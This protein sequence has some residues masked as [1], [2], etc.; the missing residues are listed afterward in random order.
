MKKGVVGFLSVL[1][2]LSSSSANNLAITNV[3]LENVGA[4]SADI[5]FDLS[6]DNSWRTTWSD[7]G[8]TVTVTNWDAVWV[9]IK[10]RQSG[11]LWQHALLTA[12]GHTA[13]GGTLVQP[14]DDSGVRLGA[15]VY[16]AA[17]SAGSRTCTDM[18]LRWDFAASGLSGTNEVDLAVMGIEMVYIPEGPF[19]LGSGGTEMN[20]FYRYPD[21][22]QPFLVTN[23]AELAVGS[24]TGQLTYTGGG[25]FGGPVPEA[26]PKGYQ[27]FYCMKYEMTEGQYT[28]FLNLL[29]PGIAS[30]YYPNKYGD[31]R[32]AITWTNGAYATDA[33][34]RACNYL[35]GDWM[36]T[37]FDW[38]GL[39]PMTEFEF[40]KVCRGVKTPWINE[41][42]W[43]NTTYVQLTGE[44]GVAG[45]GA[46]TPSPTNANLHFSTAVAGPVRAGLFAGDSSNRVDA[47][48]G[49]YGN[50][51]MSGNLRELAVGI[52]RS[53][54][55][56]FT[57]VYGD[58]NEYT[59]QPWP[60]PNS[61]RA[62]L[63]RGGGVSDNG[64]YLGRSRTS[65][66]SYSDASSMYSGQ[67]YDRGARGVRT[68]P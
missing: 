58:G 51:E 50:M 10:F 35:R 68:T 29:D 60:S 19:S 63:G 11:G 17:D 53:E 49:Y 65:D 64:T 32:H 6:W 14:A 4:T 57:D 43:G 46:E 55:R 20:R 37:Y 67:S 3:S 42:A 41:Y 59:A 12:G 25:D 40:E 38:C 15:F 21:T 62:Y 54:G 66:R 39:R 30:W 31:N 2:L 18:A 56:S 5:E 7:N 24:V 1:G 16:P 27:S 34:D 33:P 44:T 28:D 26:Y 22:A 61:G 36:L 9:F 48:A 23:E 47:G 45:S 52:N 8:D 13:S